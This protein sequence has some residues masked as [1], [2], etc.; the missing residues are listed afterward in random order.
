[1]E[2]ICP[3]C[4]KDFD[5]H[6][7]RIYCT[8][9]CRNRER[10]KRVAARNTAECSIKICDRPAAKRG[11]CQTHYA[12]WRLEGDLRPE[13]PI[14]GAHDETILDGYR[15][16]R[17]EGYLRR[18]HHVVMEGI[19]GRKLLPGENV[20]HKNGVRDDNRPENLELWVIKQPKGQ[21]PQDLVEWAREILGLYAGL[22]DQAV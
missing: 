11:W 4:K 12:R 14:R 20:H 8:T 6:P 2:K 21:R 9:T 16:I 22:A 3:S 10:E 18:E 15:F 19:I 17:H 5:G 13:D 7:Q 1:M